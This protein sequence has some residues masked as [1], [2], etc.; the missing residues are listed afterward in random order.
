MRLSGPACA[1]G[2]EVRV[3]GRG[4]VNVAMERSGEILGWTLLAVASQAG[5]G[6]GGELQVP[7]VH[8]DG[9]WKEDE[10]GEPRG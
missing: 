2:Q 7:W 8:L 5:R 9:T 6:G 10:R 1:R 3:E 4:L